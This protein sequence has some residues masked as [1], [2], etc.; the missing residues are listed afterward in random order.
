M[1]AVTP[2][3]P[4]SSTASEPAAAD[5]TAGA[6]ALALCAL[7]RISQRDLALLLERE[8]SWLVQ[9]PPAVARRCVEE[10]Y[11]VLSRGEN[12]S[13]TE[14]DAH[15]HAWAR[16]AERFTRLSGQITAARCAS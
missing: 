9:L 6:T 11:E 15:L 8:C 13:T 4:D 16:Q 14:V 1:S 7:A 2:L 5:A 3:T 10:V 12:V